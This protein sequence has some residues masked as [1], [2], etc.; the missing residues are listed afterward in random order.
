MR[1]ILGLMSVRVGEE[2]RV[3]QDEG[4]LYGH[5]LTLFVHQPLIDKNNNITN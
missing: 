5:K 4:A 3:M 2:L 1:K